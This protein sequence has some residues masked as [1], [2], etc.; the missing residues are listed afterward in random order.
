MYEQEICSDDYRIWGINIDLVSPKGKIN[1][2][3]G[4]KKTLSKKFRF[5]KINS[6]QKPL[7]ALGKILNISWITPQM[8]ILFQTSMNEKRRFIDR[9]TLSIDSL[10]LNRV[11]K[12]EK[13]LRQ[14]NKNLMQT[15]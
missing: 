4:L 3:T 7:S 6:D 8:C 1:I 2:G 5:S 10:H 11:Y 13:L 14:R 9:L 12:Y 15:D